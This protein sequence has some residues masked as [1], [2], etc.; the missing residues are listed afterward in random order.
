ML[1]GQHARG[2]SV[3]AAIALDFASSRWQTLIRTYRRMETV[4]KRRPLEVCVCYYLDAGLR[5]GDVYIEGSEAYADYRQQLLPWEACVPR[6][7]A[8][9]QALQFAPTAAE[10]V[11]ALRERLRAVAQRVDEA[12]PANTA[13]TSD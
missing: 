10:F 1:L 9:C 6:L 4:L 8:Y 5:C 7:P 11:A 13:L 3:P 12:Y 2:D